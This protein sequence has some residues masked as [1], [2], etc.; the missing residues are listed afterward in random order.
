MK[1][2]KKL[3]KNLIRRISLFTLGAS[4][5]LAGFILVAIFATRTVVA[6]SFFPYTRSYESDQDTINYSTPTNSSNYVT[7]TEANTNG[8]V[9]SGKVIT[10]STP[11]EFKLFSDRCESTAVF[12]GYNYELMC[13]IDFDATGVVDI[14]PI[15]YNTPFSGTFNGNGYEL[16]NLPMLDISDSEATSYR[17][18]VGET[19]QIQYFALFSKNSGTICNLGV[20]NPGISLNYIPTAGTAYV[21]PFVGLNTGEIHHSYTKETRDRDN[22][23]TG[24]N[25][26]GGFYLSGFAS[27]NNPV[28]GKNIHD[29]YTSRTILAAKNVRDFIAEA[30]ILNDGTAPVNAYFYDST[31]NSYTNNGNICTILFNS[32]YVYQDMFNVTHY[33]TYENTIRQLTIDVVNNDSETTLKSVGSWYNLSKYS[34]SAQTYL[35]DENGD[36]V[37]ET[38]IARGIVTDSD[39][40]GLEFTITNNREYSYMFELFLVNKSF[41]TSVTTFK[42][43]TN[44]DM[45]CIHTPEYQSDIGC[46]IVGALGGTEEAAITIYNAPINDYYAKTIGFY[47]FGVFPLLTG[48]VS[49][50]NV[51]LGSTSTP[52]NFTFNRGSDRNKLAVG[53]ISGYVDGGR[54]D[55]CNVYLNVSFDNAIGKYYFGGIAGMVG[56]TSTSTGIVSNSTVNGNI[57]QT[58]TSVGTA[59]ETINYLDGMVLGGAVGYLD[60][61]TGS[62]DTVLSTVDIASRGVTGKSFS[63]G[64][65]VGAGYA[66]KLNQLQYEASIDLSNS[67][68]NYTNL[69]ASGVVGR[70]LGAKEQVDYLTNK[71]NISLYQ[72][73]N[74]E[75]YISGL[76]NVDIITSSTSYTPIS[77][78]PLMSKGSYL[79]YGASFTN[80]ADITITNQS[81]NLVYTEVLNIKSGNGFTSEL[82]GLYN[83]ETQTNI[84]IDIVKIKKFAPVINNINGSADYK[85][86]VQTAYNFKDIAIT[87][88][89]ASATDCIYAGVGMG[90]YINYTNVH[91]LGDITVFIT[92]VFGTNENNK[93]NLKVSGVFSEV[94]PSCKANN[95]YNAGNINITYTAMVYGNIYAAGIC[96]A[97][98]NGF[99]ND[100]IKRFDP[101]SDKYQSDAVG[102]INNAIN[103]GQIEVTNPNYSSL[104]MTNKFEVKSANGSVITENH[105]YSSHPSVSLYGNINVSGITNFNYSAITN[106]FNIADLFAANYIRSTSRNEI[107]VSGL[108]TYNIGQ[109]AVIENSANDGVV[110]AINLSFYMIFDNGQSS[111]NNT[112]AQYAFVNASGIVCHNDETDTGAI[113]DN[114]GTHSKQIIAFTINYGSIYS[115]NVARNSTSSS[116]ESFR[117]ISAGIL[118][119]GLLNL[120]NVVNYGNVYGSEV[121]GGI[122]GV[123]FFDS[124]NTEVNS[125]NKV[126]LANTINYANVL[127][128]DKGE[129]NYRDSKYICQTYDSFRLLNNNSTVYYVSIPVYSQDYFNG[130]IFGIINFSGSTNA[131]NVII[132]YLISFNKDVS[133]VGAEAQTPEVVVDLSTFYSAYI[134]Y[135]GSYTLDTYIGQPVVYSPLST[136]SERINGVTYYGVFND[137]FQFR[138]AMNGN[139][140][141]LN[142]A[143]YP[144][145]SFITDYFEFVGASYVND[146][147]LSTIGWETI[148]FDAAAENFATSLEGV[149]KFVSYVGDNVSSQYNSLVTAALN[150]DTWLSRCSEDDLIGIVS[151]LIENESVMELESIINYIFQSSSKS[152]SIINS[153]TRVRLLELLIENDSTID[154]S[155]LLETIIVY[156]NGFSSL[157]ADSVLG[158]NDAGNYLYEYLSSLSNSNIKSILT[159][160][161]GYLDDNNVNSYFL[162]SNSSQK[163]YDILSAIFAGIDDP[164]FYNNLSTILGV[165]SEVSLYNVSDDMAMYSGYQT[166]T[167]SEKTSLYK[168]ILLNNSYGDLVT[169]VNGMSS[170]IDYYIRLINSG[171]LKTSLSNIYSDISSSASSST[172]SVIDERIDLWNQIRHTEVFKQYLS[173]RL[174]NPNRYIAKA[175]EVNNTYQTTTTPYP[176]ADSSYGDLSFTYTFNIT[177]LTNFLGPY[178]S[179]GNVGSTGVDNFITINSDISP[180][181]GDTN[182]KLY[183]IVDVATKAEA[184]YLYNNGYTY[185]YQLFYYEYSDSNSNNQFC[186]IQ[187]PGENK[188]AFT[189]FKTSYK[190]DFTGGFLH[191]TYDDNGDW[192]DEEILVEDSNGETF[193]ANGG[194]ISAF[195][196]T[197]AAQNPNNTSNYT[198]NTINNNLAGS[199]VITD[200]NQKQHTITGHVQDWANFIIAHEVRHYISYPRE[201]LHET[202]FSGLIRRRGQS[203]WFTFNSAGQVRSFQYIDYNVN[204]LLALDGYLTSYLDGTTRSDDEREIINGLYES[205][206][207]TDHT[208]FENMVAAALLEKN[209][210][211]NDDSYYSVGTA[212]YNNNDY[213]GIPD[214]YNSSK[215]FYRLEVTTPTQYDS[216]AK[217]FK[218]VRNNAYYDYIEVRSEEVNS[219]NYSSYYL[220]NPT[221]VYDYYSYSDCYQQKDVDGYDID[222]LNTYFLTNIY[223]D[224]RIE[225][226]EPL[227]FLDV[228]SQITSGS[229]V[230]VKGYLKSLFNDVT[231]EKFIAYNVDNQNSY[232]RLLLELNEIDNL[233]IPSVGYPVSIG[234]STDSDAITLPKIIS[235]TNVNVVNSQTDIEDKSFDCGYVFSNILLDLDS[236]F[237]RLVLYVK[238]VGG[239]TTLSYSIDNGTILS[240]TVSSATTISIPLNGNES[241][242][243]M[244]N[245]DV[246]LFYAYEIKNGLS[247]IDNESV[248]LVDQSQNIPNADGLFICYLP[249]AT[250]LLNQK[251]LSLN[252]N[253]IYPIDLSLSASITVISHNYGSSGSAH[254]RYHRLI[255]DNDG[256]SA[257][258]DGTVIGTSGN[259]IMSN[260][261]FTFPTLDETYLGSYLGLLSSTN[262]T[263]YEYY[264]SKRQGGTG[265]RVRFY[266]ITMMLTYTYSISNDEAEE[267]IK[268]VD[269]YNSAVNKNNYAA[270]ECC[271]ALL[272]GHTDYSDRFNSFIHDATYNLIPIDYAKQQYINTL[273]SSTYY[274]DNSGVK[275]L[276]TGEYSST[277]T[278]YTESGG[279]YTQATINEATYYQSMTSNL[280]YVESGGSYSFA[281]GEYNSATTYYVY[282]NSEYKEASID[283]INLVTL[284]GLNGAHNENITLEYCIPELLEKLITTSN[285]AFLSFINN[286]VVTSI[287]KETDYEILL[288]GLISNVG[289]YVLSDA[290]Y[291]ISSTLSNEVKNILAA[292][293]LVTNY[294]TILKNQTSV[295]DSYLRNYIDNS[296]SND[297]RYIQ[298]DDSYDREKFEAFAR[299]IGY[300]LST[301]GYGIYALASSYGI[302][303]GRFIPDN[304]VL[305]S[306]NPYYNKVNN[307]YVI[308]NTTDAYWRKGSGSLDDAI[309]DT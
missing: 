41:A 275:A 140:E 299:L 42:I 216:N 86:S 174:S 90:D 178:D 193:D 122:V 57:T 134:V 50:V 160:Y 215:I 227:Q 80:K 287:N 266:T 83:L 243:L 138:Q 137:R 62:V 307:K 250:T 147:L 236:S 38:P 71:G 3:N 198:A 241:I 179:S 237:D 292:A 70:L 37:Y 84:S 218:R 148:A 115:Y 92:N 274:V 225:S 209:A 72:K 284:L 153:A 82:S 276:A 132:R 40:N 184:D 157:L 95:I 8:S 14:V 149:S 96:Y 46:N 39:T 159:T 152:Y 49:Y 59:D 172:T 231:K 88:S 183:S 253:G 161:C 220:V 85:V 298:S 135:D 133:L 151:E 268:E 301:T 212:T 30:E 73:T 63:I 124:F 228:P 31:I 28:S 79:F 5:F 17:Y 155:S 25:T 254:E 235:Y 123:M 175:T 245:Q 196:S 185:S 15:G 29:V 286:S 36:W 111:I 264:T 32:N 131:V 187:R 60:Y 258:I 204:Q 52:Y 48:S 281:T 6:E 203:R 304:L 33:G 116:S 246:I 267:L 105:F 165:S 91:N 89:A 296:L 294:K 293:Y 194:G 141:Y 202:K 97:N 249:A 197:T 16:R 139:D 201:N 210:I 256:N 265:Y 207:V 19:H 114:N 279:V 47:C 217:Y 77:N 23:A 93:N 297:Y 65:V 66:Y 24:I 120:V 280:Y 186:A 308:T 45:A 11:Q 112:T 240:T 282:E 113:Y 54:I 144:T 260:R 288:N 222:Y 262:G 291:N 199:W 192:I 110:K 53:V 69:Y 158:D 75:S 233:S 230:S 208:N 309:T 34:S 78:N 269:I 271:G 108:V 189:W 100:E 285:E 27:V 283:R 190:T 67:S 168:A 214:Y 263:T 127:V 68:I 224:S 21:A 136:N 171:Y 257:T 18:V 22:N 81:T 166:L 121:S 221:R 219:T 101:S 277:T 129:L 35:K 162:Y 12:L 213:V 252:S 182:E 61:T 273:V 142:I 87:T 300:S 180:T 177:P 64:G 99:S 130:S 272:K 169:Y 223:T 188:Y 234:S 167:E 176:L 117:T 290:V 278:Y 206:F 244:A 164:V 163:R 20:I 118:G 143:T 259:K 181:N 102:S 154:Y 119:M 150:T 106:T 104:G 7:M 26:V 145:D 94:S 238:P 55:N 302:E 248:T 173:S 229:L 242:N 56:S 305:S 195:T 146:H 10:I 289:Y 170:E 109:F 103:N 9:A 270:E 43:T 239:S 98:K 156:N 58:N 13:D 107:N 200:I 306:M 51:V 226:I 4:L 191:G 125:S 74:T 255:V 303:D 205:F 295:Y 126:T 251:L 2:N 247:G 128:I 44:I 232:A 1:K 261:T 211:I 76:M